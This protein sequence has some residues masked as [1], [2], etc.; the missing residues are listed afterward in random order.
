MIIVTINNAKLKHLIKN[1]VDNT[2]SV[3]APLVGCTFFLTCLSF[4]Y[5]LL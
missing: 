1:V 4:T 2:G 3:R 5:L